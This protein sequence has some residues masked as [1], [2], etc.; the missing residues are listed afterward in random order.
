ME[1]DLK[2]GT[3]SE[4]AYARKAKRLIFALKPLNEQRLCTRF[5]QS[6]ITSGEAIPI[7]NASDV[8]NNVNTI[9]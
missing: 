1:G 9:I 5:P 8:M 3:A 2:T 7:E 6:L 4:I